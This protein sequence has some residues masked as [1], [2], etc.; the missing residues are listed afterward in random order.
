M[1]LDTVARFRL[2]PLIYQNSDV[3]VV[4]I[5][6]GALV[7][8]LWRAIYAHPRLKKYVDE[9]LRLYKVSLV[10]YII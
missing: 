1:S 10:L 8:D 2:L 5:Q 7:E 6:R 4:D 3:F 9:T